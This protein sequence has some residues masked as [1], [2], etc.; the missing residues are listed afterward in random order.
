M[1]R[2]GRGSKGGGK[3]AKKYVPS[4]LYPGSA[5]VNYEPDQTPAYVTSINFYLNSS[6]C[7]SSYL[8]WTY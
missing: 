4:F 5:P 7:I 6:N 3:Y 2:T 1:P 8:I